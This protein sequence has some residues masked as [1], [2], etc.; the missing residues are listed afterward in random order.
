MNFHPNDFEKDVMKTAS[1]IIKEFGSAAQC[2]VYECDDK[3][4]L[5]KFSNAFDAPTFQ[6]M[7][8]ADK[9][10]TAEIDPSAEVYKR[11]VDSEAERL[12]HF[13]IA[14]YNKSNR[15]ISLMS[16]IERPTKEED[17]SVRSYDHKTIQSV[18]WKRW[19]NS[20]A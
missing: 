12:A 6:P 15:K 11:C 13:A 20:L 1:D 19:R 8:P 10:V 5:Q 9:L 2:P 18:I 17:L 16:A 4:L 3:S 14:E 7:I